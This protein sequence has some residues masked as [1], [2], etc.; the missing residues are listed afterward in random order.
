MTEPGALPTGEQPT[1]T[2]LADAD[3]L[4]EHLDDLNEVGE[5][6]VAVGMDASRQP[7]LITLVGPYVEDEDVIFDS[8]WQSDCDYGERI[9]GEWVPHPPRCD[10]CQA[11]VHGIEDL[12]F[13]VTVLASS[14]HPQRARDDE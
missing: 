3:A 2:V 8:P 14:K 6:P 12:R 13:P 10:E 7:F 11:Q 4:R 5:R 9:S 1:V